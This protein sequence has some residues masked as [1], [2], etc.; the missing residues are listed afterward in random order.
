MCRD[1]TLR[2]RRPDLDP[3]RLG[4]D[5]QLS[6]QLARSAGRAPG[7]VAQ[8]LWL[9]VCAPMGL[10]DAVQPC[11]H[12]F[13]S[14]RECTVDGRLRVGRRWPPLSAQ[15]TFSA[16]G[17]RRIGIGRHHALINI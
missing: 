17:V 5:A 8:T 10:A 7:P 1:P 2:A 16:A 3:R 11:S 14:S 4:R 9:V 13:H 6:T 15:L 12:G